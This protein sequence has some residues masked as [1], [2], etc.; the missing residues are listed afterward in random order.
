MNPKRILLAT[1][2]SCRCDR[3]LDR[4]VALATEWKG[5][6]VA[7]HALETPLPVIDAPSWQRTTDAREL[8]ARR[9][10]ADLRGAAI[11]LEVIVERGDAAQLVLE[12][13]ERSRC[14]LVVTGIARDETLGRAILGGTVE[15]LLPRSKVP[16]LVVKSRPRGPY[17]NVLVATD[18]SDSS[19]AAL[20][21]ALAMFSES[22]VSL[23][24]AY[25]VPYEGFMHDQ[26]A[27]RDQVGRDARREC[28][29]FLT[30]IPAAKGRH[31]PIICEYGSPTML[32]RDLIEEGG[33]DLVVAG[34]QG[35]GRAATLL[36]GSVAQALLG[37]LPGDVMI[38]PRA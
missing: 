3:A 25:E 15:A 21:T 37:A 9:I 38:V 26:M 31:I 10:R 14:E 17:R 6:V 8:A 33:V 22:L 34:T 1:D 30:R 36:L 13:A 23:F 5:H 2:L 29:E 12:A 16:V 11:E 18:F 24:H 20:E 4:T 19:R 35:R 7:V 32:L 28:E 27:V